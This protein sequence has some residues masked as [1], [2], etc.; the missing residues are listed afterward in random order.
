MGEPPKRRGPSERRKCERRR[1]LQRWRYQ[2]QYHQAV[3]VEALY[4]GRSWDDPRGNEREDAKWGQAEAPFGWGSRSKQ[5]RRWPEYPE[6]QRPLHALHPPQPRSGEWGS[7][8][9]P[10]S[11]TSPSHPSKLAIIQKE[12]THL[13]NT[14]NT[15]LPGIFP[16]NGI[17]PFFPHLKT[18]GYEDKNQDAV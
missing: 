14:K 4:R 11:N 1:F 18:A 5:R 8:G 16:G 12:K 7:W 2:Q 10:H 15:S 17:N 9:I 3:Q 6:P 13:E